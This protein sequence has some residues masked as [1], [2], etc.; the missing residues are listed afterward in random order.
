LINNNSF[1]NTQ[2]LE[3]WWI[4]K[5]KLLYLS[6]NWLSN[7]STQQRIY[8]LAHLDKDQTRWHF[9][10]KQCPSSFGHY[11]YALPREHRAIPPFT[12]G[13]SLCR[14]EKYLKM[15]KNFYCMP[16]L[17]GLKFELMVIKNEDTGCRHA[18]N[19]ILGSLFLN[20]FWDLTLYGK[21]TCPRWL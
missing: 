15:T 3:H 17:N 14:K 5:W 18:Y 7:N 20:W 6:D 11:F 19:M 4:K 16:F 10:L 1:I 2:V 9:L 12:K 8:I 13:E 21:H